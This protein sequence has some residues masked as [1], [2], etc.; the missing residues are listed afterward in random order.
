[1]KIV[2]DILSNNVITAL[3]WNIFH[4]LWQGLLIA[5]I[6]SLLLRLLRGKSSQVRYMISLF[7]LLLFF[8]LSIINFTANYEK[9][10]KERTLREQI[11]LNQNQN[12]LLVDFNNVNLN[13]TF[14]ETIAEIKNQIVKIDRYFPLIV[15]VWILG[16]FAFI[17]KFVLSYVYTSR[18][19]RIGVKDLSEDWLDRFYKL[20][21]KLNINKTVNYIES[22]LVKI[23][24][25]LG[26]LK[27]VIVIPV[28]MLTGIPSNQIEAIIAHELAHIRRNDYI[29][30]VLQT[31]IETM[32][33]FHPAVWYI[34][35]QIRKERENSCD[36]IALTVCE[37]SLVYAKALVSIQEFSLNRLYSAVAFSGRKKHLLNRIKRM[38]MKPQNKSNFTDKIIASIII[39]SGVLALS[40]TNKADI[41]EYTSENGIANDFIETMYTSNSD[42][43]ETKVINPIVKDS[44][45]IRK[46]DHDEINI[47][48]NT[49]VRTYNDHG[50]KRK[51]EFTIKNGKVTQLIVDGKEI[52]ENEFN[53]YQSEIDET[54]YDLKEAKVDIRN[55]LKEIEE[56]DIE[57][58][59][60]EVQEAMKDVH[61]DIAEMQKEVAIAIEEAH[62]I[63]VEDI[64]NE[65]E[66]NIRQI[67]D[68][69]IDFDFDHDFD[70]EI[71]DI[72]IDMDQIREELEK[73][74]ES[75]RENIDMEAIEKEMQ[76]VQEEL[77]KIDHEQIKLQIE[78]GLKSFEQHDKEKVMR[79]L[80]EK[81]E[82]LEQLE[83]EEK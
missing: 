5:A 10:S 24:V 2:S 69:D 30:N 62:A 8:G 66:T 78:E 70:I 59:H 44:V 33:F 49:I 43:L 6:L 40:F 23:P 16:V 12:S 68:L 38:I 26:W 45:N 64:L 77:S 41:T 32:F 1:M 34:S 50:S 46:H 71:D 60:K 29:F 21:K 37:G 57:K 74:R 47:E 63:D 13:H 79:D 52:P 80:E 75:I 9:E 18:L 73:T 11:S 48:D 3:G 25:V 31:I 55:A 20:Q 15:T 7:S 83:L 42:A 65:V 22:T 36:D 61:I 35:A 17:L 72:H 53:K 82:E 39:I 27:P 58:I 54:I 67:K 19:K 56:L 81:L 28:E 14:R 4:I 51:M 76:K